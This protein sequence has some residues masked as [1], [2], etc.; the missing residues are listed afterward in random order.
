MQHWLVKSEPETYAWT[1][2][3]KDGRTTWDGVRNFQARNNLQQMQPGDLVLFY[4]SVSEKAVVGI[5]KV[6]KAAYPDPTADDPKWVAVDLVPFRDFREP[7]TLEQIK[8]DKRLENIALLRQSR[9]SVMPL[10]G[11][12]FDV[13]L[14]LGN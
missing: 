13:L 9:L 4:H 5:A 8:K 7:V 6:D 10:T 2:L 12:E 3:V 11:E 14:A 1:D